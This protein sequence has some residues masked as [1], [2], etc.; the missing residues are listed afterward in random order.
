MPNILSN[1]LK[2]S[3]LSGLFVFIA[4]LGFT[5]CCLILCFIPRNTLVTC[6]YSLR[7]TNFFQKQPLF[8]SGC[9]KTGIKIIH[10]TER[11]L[12]F[13]TDLQKQL[14]SILHFC[15]YVKWYLKYTLKVLKSNLDN[16]KSSR[17]LSK[18]LEKDNVSLLFS[19]FQVRHC[20]FFNLNPTL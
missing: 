17:K 1:S 2:M 12:K 4:P 7:N 11:G 13:H 6:W 18:A 3:L 9:L 20:S 8:S 14:K 10:T 5:I 15:Q 16:P 19:I